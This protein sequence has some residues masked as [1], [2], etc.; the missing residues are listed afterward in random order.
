MAGKK[1]YKRKR[2][3]DQSAIELKG[4]PH[5]DEAERVLLGVMMLEA[6]NI[7]PVLDVVT[8]ED[9]YRRH[10]F[11]IFQALVLLFERDDEIDPVL[12]ADELI[13]R[14]ELEDA[15]GYEYLDQLT[16]GIPR[17]TNIEHYAN[18]VKEKAMLRKLAH[19]GQK[20]T[21][22]S[23]S[24]EMDAMSAIGVAENSLQEF[25]EGKVDHGFRDFGELVVETY[26]TMRERA[27]KGDELVGLRTGFMDWD[28]MTA[29]L[30]KGDLIIV[31]ARPAM[32]KTSFVLNVALNSAVKDGKNVALFSLEMPGAQLVMR[33]IGSEAR[34]SISSLRTGKLME[35]EWNRVALAVG[36]L[37][38]S[39][40]FIEDSGESTVAQMRAQLKRLNSEYGVDLVVIDYLQLMSGSTLQQQQS[41]VQ[42]VSAIS[43]G[44]KIMAKE[45]DAPV[46][47]LS[48]LSRAA[49]QRSDKRPQLSDLRES[50]SIEQDADMVCFLYREDYYQEKEQV[51][52]DKDPDE[53]EFGIAELIIAK[54]RNGATGSVNLAFFKKYTRFENYSEDMEFA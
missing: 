9:F 31:A 17:T 13:K 16:H 47:A 35:E 49:E 42:E 1:D 19:F 14:D 3:D 45:I 41:R 4:F 53:Q 25:R 50:G 32:G 15:G 44:L 37:G 52:D 20:L 8:P 2:D 39:N 26:E 29:G 36:E 10:H 48:Q 28:R 7:A 23:I 33:L 43:R 40:I 46:I 34:V 11:L 38:Q 21:E 54:H 5:H 18:I 51:V 27:A 6:D 24:G 22:I 30:Q 12:V